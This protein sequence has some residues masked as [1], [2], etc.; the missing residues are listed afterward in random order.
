[1]VVTT[2]TYAARV[3]EAVS[4]VEAQ[5]A[6]NSLPT[7]PVERW[8]TEL[9]VRFSQKWP[10]LFLDQWSNRAGWSCINV[11]VVTTSGYAARVAEAVSLVEAQGTLHCS[12]GSVEQP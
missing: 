1:M 11:I 9:E 8:E 7:S 10:Y 3:A 4:L 12:L 5:G 6:L 2:S